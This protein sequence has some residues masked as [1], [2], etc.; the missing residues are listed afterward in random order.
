MRYASF[1]MSAAICAV[2]AGCGAA[3]PASG[4]VGQPN[5]APVR[6]G[7]TVA[8]VQ[9]A[10]NTGVEPQQRGAAR[11]I[12]IHTGIKVL[13]DANL[14]VSTVRLDAPYATPV[15][16]VAI[17]DSEEGMLALLGRAK[18]IRTP[19][20]TAY[21]YFPDAATM[22]TFV[23]NPQHKVETIFLEH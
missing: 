3:G 19:E 7:A 8:E 20:Q 1:V 22:L 15:M 6:L 2:L 18:I 9:K 17:G 12:V 21:T 16:G 4:V 23:V 11:E 10:L 14:K 5:G 13:F